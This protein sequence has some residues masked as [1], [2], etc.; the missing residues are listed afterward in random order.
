MTFRSR[1]R[2]YLPTTT[3][4]RE[5]AQEMWP[6]ALETT[7]IARTVRALPVPFLHMCFQEG[8]LMKRFLLL[9]CLCCLCP[10]LLVACRWVASSSTWM[11]ER[12]RTRSM[13]VVLS[14][15]GRNAKLKLSFLQNAEG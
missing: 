9:M 5:T 15:R 12:C 10:A 6:G 14:T 11:A 1:W 7:N 3:G 8:N 4:I 13:A 2:G